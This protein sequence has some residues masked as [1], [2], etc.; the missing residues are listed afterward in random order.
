MRRDKYLVYVSFLET[1]LIGR[2][3]SESSFKGLLSSSFIEQKSY[4]VAK[5]LSVTLLKELLRVV[6][7]YLFFIF[8]YNFF[9]AVLVFVTLLNQEFAFI[10][11]SF[12]SNLGPL[13]L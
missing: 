9:V 3:V 4:Q 12:T 2:A 5:E 7:I 6:F 11:P 13:R 10:F 1:M 8:L